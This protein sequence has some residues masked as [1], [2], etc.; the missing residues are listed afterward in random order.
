MTFEILSED[1]SKL[2]FLRDDR[3][4]EFHAQYGLHH[5]TRIPKFGRAMAY[6]SDNCDLYLC[7]V[8]CVAAFPWQ[9]FLCLAF[10]FFFR[11]AQ[12]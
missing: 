4:V 11:R 2:V 12:K 5:R 1:Y 9:H 3:V 10:F 6:N 8:G 7:G